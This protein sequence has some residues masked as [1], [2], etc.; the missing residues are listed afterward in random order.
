MRGPKPSYPI[1]LT[2]AEEE[3]L[4]QMARAHTTG[5]AQ[6]IRG[7]ILLCDQYDSFDDE[8]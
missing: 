2:K 6:A 8:Y 4:R 7:R 5:Q 1:A 3:Q